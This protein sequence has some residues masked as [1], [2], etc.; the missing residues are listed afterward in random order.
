M[1]NTFTSDVSETLPIAYY[2][3]VTRFVLTTDF[4]Q[5]TLKLI[6]RIVLVTET[7]SYNGKDNK[8]SQGD[9]L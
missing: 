8:Y 7:N 6:N 2:T 4:L 5:Y 3:H 9:R 1:A